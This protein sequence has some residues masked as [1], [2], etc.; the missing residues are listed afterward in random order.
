MQR[1]ASQGW[2]MPLQGNPGK[3]PATYTFAS[4]KAKVHMKTQVWATWLEPVKGCF[5]K[6]PSSLMRQEE[7]VWHFWKKRFQIY[8]N[9]V[10]VHESSKNRCAQMRVANGK[11]RATR[12]GGHRKGQ[13]HPILGSDITAVK[14]A[15]NGPRTSCVLASCDHQTPKLTEWKHLTTWANHV[16][17]LSFFS[18]TYTLYLKIEFLKAAPWSFI[19]VDA[20]EDNLVSL[21]RNQLGPQKALSQTQQRDTKSNLMKCGRPGAPVASFFWS[22]S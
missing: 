19:Y 2:D 6:P 21:Y 11:Q 16:C 14:E 20:L 12:L 9:L 18:Q 17:I 15:P 8:T 5:M 1:S 7:L 4:S 22:A 10:S 13:M 3:K